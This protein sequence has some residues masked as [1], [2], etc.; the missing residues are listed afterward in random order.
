MTK[1]TSKSLSARGSLDKRN[2]VI[3]PGS[4]PGNAERTIQTRKEALDAGY[5]IDNHCYPN[6]AYKGQRFQ[7]D[8]WFKVLTEYEEQLTF[9]F[10]HYKRYKTDADRSLDLMSIT[11]KAQEKQI[12]K[13]TTKLTACK[14]SISELT[15]RNINA[16]SADTTHLMSSFPEIRR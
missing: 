11:L 13:L 16:T 5:I 9:K 7:P 4:S 1:K 15:H 2:Q 3:T 8:H 10:D 12:H 6:V 14:K